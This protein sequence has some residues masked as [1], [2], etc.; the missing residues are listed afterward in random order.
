MKI[1]LKPCLIPCRTQQCWAYW[2]IFNTEQGQV[3]EK[4][5]MAG[6]GYQLDNDYMG[7]FAFCQKTYSA[8]EFDNTTLNK[9]T[10]FEVFQFSQFTC[11]SFV[12]DA[13]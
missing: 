1:K 13:V 6:I 4:M 5:L 10:T 2:V 8:F 3:S 9:K 11:T 12:V 7:Y